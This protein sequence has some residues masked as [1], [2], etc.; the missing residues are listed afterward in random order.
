MTYFVVNTAFPLVTEVRVY[1]ETIDHIRDE[2]PEIPIE[3]PSLIHGMTNTLEQP[4]YIEQGNRPNTYVY[5]DPTSTNASGDPFR[6]P[7]KIISGT[8]ALVKTA[9]FASPENPPLIVWRRGDE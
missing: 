2:H 9:F 5:V 8:S 3:L 7:V 4:A 1:A 6:V